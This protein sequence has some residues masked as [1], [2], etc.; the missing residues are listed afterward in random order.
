LE[1]VTGARRP[2]FR[3]PECPTCGT[4]FVE[5]PE[6]GRVVCSGCRQ[7]L[8]LALFH[9][10]ERSVPQAQAPLAGA[11]PCA[12]HARNAAVA[13]CEHCGAF[14]CTL[15]RV[16]AEGTPLCA[17]CFDR[18]AASGTLPS[19]RMG[20]RHYNGIAVLLA[21]VGLMPPFSVVAGP[22]AVASAW[23]GLHQG[24]QLGETLG[25]SGAKV[26]LALGLLEAA[27]GVAFWL[28]LFAGMK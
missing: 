13:S 11:A 15:C 26:A 6:R 12:R 24:R 23:K 2:P 3:G 5:P 1:T 7:T 22:L 28:F 14:M 4:V 21:L 9:P 19:A 16:D 8:E 25:A 10:K 20:Y 27:G 17:A 18:L